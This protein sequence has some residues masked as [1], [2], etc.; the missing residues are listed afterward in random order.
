MEVHQ[1]TV[2]SYLSS[3]FANTI[4]QSKNFGNMNN[5]IKFKKNN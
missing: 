1:G 4:D 5:Y 2:D 3:L